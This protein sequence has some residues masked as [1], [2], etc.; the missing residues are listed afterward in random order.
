MEP[1]SYPPNAFN[2]GTDLILLEPEQE[3]RLSFHIQ[4]RLGPGLAFSL[5]FDLSP[6][7]YSGD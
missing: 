1:M 3:H 7:E 2:S 4:G 6:E 5:R